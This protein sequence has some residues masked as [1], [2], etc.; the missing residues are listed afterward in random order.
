MEGP[1]LLYILFAGLATVAI[2]FG[3]IIIR[4]DRKEAKQHLK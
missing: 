3:A 1:Q 2:F 4:Q